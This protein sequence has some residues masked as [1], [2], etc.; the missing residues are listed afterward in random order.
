MRLLWC[1]MGYLGKQQQ[2]RRQNLMKT[3][4]EYI[5]V[6]KDLDIFLI[7]LFQLVHHTIF[8]YIVLN[9]VL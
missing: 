2:N 6:V 5:Y 1:A 3:I 9:T 4:L 8:H 7:V